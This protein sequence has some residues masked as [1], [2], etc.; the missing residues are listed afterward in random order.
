M[1][2][3]YEISAATG[4]GG[5]MTDAIDD[6]ALKDRLDAF[7]RRLEKRIREFKERGEFS[8]IHDVS[9]KELRKHHDL[10]RKRLRAAVHEGRPWNVLKDEIERD[11]DALSERFVKWDR[12]LEAEM[13]KTEGK[14]RS[15]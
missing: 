13:M 2:H 14:K 15:P 10:L 3:R 7:S 9:M 1:M 4:K 5:P 8:S 12:H 11:L 6:S